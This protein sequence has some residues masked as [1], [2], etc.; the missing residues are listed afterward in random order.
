MDR[1]TMIDLA[2][3]DPVYAAALGAVS[4]DV[5]EDRLYIEIG[6]AAMAILALQRYGWALVRVEALPN[7]PTET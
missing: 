5:D 6:R 1:A 2:K 7:T 3:T 4:A